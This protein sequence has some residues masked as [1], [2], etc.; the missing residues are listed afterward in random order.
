MNNMGEPWEV[1]VG[2]GGSP[3]VKTIYLCIKTIM[4]FTIM[5]W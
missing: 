5:I 1:K 2:G 4:M 3:Q